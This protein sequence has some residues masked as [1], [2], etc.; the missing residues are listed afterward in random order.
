M[1]HSEKQNCPVIKFQKKYLFA[2]IPR[3]QPLGLLKRRRRRSRRTGLSAWLDSL[4][5]KL[6][7]LDKCELQGST[8]IINALQFV[9]KQWY[10]L[11]KF[12]GHLKNKK[13]TP[14]FDKAWLPYSDLVHDYKVSWV[15]RHQPPFFLSSFSIIIITCFV[16]I[17]KYMLHYPLL[18]CV[19]TMY[20]P[21]TP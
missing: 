17:E 19:Y 15:H 11:K 4:P 5:A 12:S 8:P 14:L 7:V 13:R 18:R 2:I 21:N 6:Y 20:V 10:T 1:Q 9:L 16:S 3:V